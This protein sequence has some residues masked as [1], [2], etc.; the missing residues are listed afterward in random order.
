MQ[1][2]A[3]PWYLC[4]QCVHFENTNVHSKVDI[5]CPPK[6]GHPLVPGTNVDNE[7]TKPNS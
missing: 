3:I 7:W 5:F 4:P 1:H 2:D 6:N